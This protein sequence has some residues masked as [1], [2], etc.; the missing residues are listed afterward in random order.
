[1]RATLAN[2]PAVPHSPAESKTHQGTERS[3]V[4]GRP[5]VASEGYTRDDRVRFLSS[6]N[7]RTTTYIYIYSVYVGIRAL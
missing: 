3:R 5:R 4:S 1:M 6:R 7:N 2:V